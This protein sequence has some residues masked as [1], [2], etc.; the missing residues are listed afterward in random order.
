MKE[1]ERSGS[2]LLIVDYQTE[3]PIGCGKT[4]SVCLLVSIEQIS[5]QIASVRQD[6]P[7]ERKF[8]ILNADLSISSFDNRSVMES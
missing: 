6:W 3:R 4:K 8:E 7:L 1:E 5:K 2:T